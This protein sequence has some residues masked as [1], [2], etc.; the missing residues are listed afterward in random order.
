MSFE[1]LHHRIPIDDAPVTEL[2][3]TKPNNCESHGYTDLANV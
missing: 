1:I 2:P 3:K